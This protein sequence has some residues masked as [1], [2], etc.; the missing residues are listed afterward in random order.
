[1]F[2]IETD[3]LILREPIIADFDFLKSLWEDG[4]VMNYVGFPDSL[5]QPDDKIIDWINS[6]QKDGNCKLVIEDKESGKSWRTDY[7]IIQYKK[8]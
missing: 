7:R 2:K 1:M 5:K 6:A 4:R 8:K 3:R